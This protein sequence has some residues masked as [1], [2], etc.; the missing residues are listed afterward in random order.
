MLPAIDVV[1]AAA[2]LRRT[3]FNVCGVY[4]L[5]ATFVTDAAKLISGNLM[6]LAAMV[7]LELPHVNVLSK[8]DLIDKN[9]LDKYLSPSGA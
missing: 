7:H 2:A 9:V 4:L 1:L 5:D 6:A 3:G 8:C